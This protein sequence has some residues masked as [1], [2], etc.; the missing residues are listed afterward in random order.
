M[1][2]EGQAAIVTGG[3]RGIGRA[4]ALALARAGAAVLVLARTAAEV[5]AVAEEIRDSGGLGLAHSGDVRHA[6][7][8]AAAAEHA[9]R[10]FGGVHILVNAAGIQGP[11]GPLWQNDVAAWCET[12]E[13]HVLGTFLSCRA[14]LPLM[15]AARRGK[16]INF[17]GG[18][19]AGPRENFSAYAASKAG[20]V[21]LTETLA[22]EVKQHNIQVNAIA[23]GA[24]F[25]RLTE[26]VIAADSAAGTEG[27]A[28]AQRTRDARALPDR[29]VELVLFLVSPESAQLTGR[30]VSAM[31]DDW[32]AMA[33]DFS[34]LA[35]AGGYTLRRL[36]PHILSRAAESPALRPKKKT[37]ESNTAVG[38]RSHAHRD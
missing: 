34:E 25:T 19:A 35:A 1:N 5:N 20:V 7:T 37:P 10:A 38:G 12:L 3:G 30:L 27:L 32:P 29:A 31:W 17:S 9:T 13:T 28:E 14:V 16:I 22:E 15:L 2:L 6:D 23:P 36:D 4:V 11:I 21:R 24:V 8:L 26:Q 18:G 33:R